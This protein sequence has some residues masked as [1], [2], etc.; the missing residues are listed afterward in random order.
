VRLRS[1]RVAFSGERDGAA[2]A[3]FGAGMMGSRPASPVLSKRDREF[4]QLAVTYAS[5]RQ[6]PAS[7]CAVST[8]PPGLRDAGFVR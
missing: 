1:L 6:A 3:S 7:L 8:G 2:S 4:T 5:D